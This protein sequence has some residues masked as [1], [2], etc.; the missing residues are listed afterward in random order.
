MTACVCGK[1]SAGRGLCDNCY[2]VHRR[3]QLAY[4]RWDPDRRDPTPSREH[5]AA[6]RAAGM[7]FRR[8]SA[9]TGLSRPTLQCIA[10]VQFVTTNTERRILA[11]PIPAA[12][13]DTVL[14]PGTQIC[15]V[16]SARR[17]RS[18]ARMGWSATVVGAALGVTHARVTALT[19]GRQSKVTAARA[20]A[21]AD[22]FDRWHM[23]TG[24]SRKAARIAELKGWPFPLAWDEDTIDDPAAEPAGVRRGDAPTSVRIVDLQ[25]L[26]VTDIEVIA[27]R[28]RIQPKSVQRQLLRLQEAS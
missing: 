28:L 6:L 4:G 15:A 16:G 13:F 18:L 27:E 10:R 22:V 14:A 5:L 8:V 12:Q 7:G 9:L 2:A 3:K 26:G 11:V 24:P 17:L 19:S 21:I 25:D 1:P 23:T 20:H